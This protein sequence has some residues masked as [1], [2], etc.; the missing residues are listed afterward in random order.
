MAGALIKVDEFTVDSAVSS[1][2]LGGGSSGSSGLN[3]SI[4]STFDVYM[5]QLTNVRMATDARTLYIRFTAS[6]TPNTTSNYDRAMLNLRTDATF[7]E[8]HNTN[9]TFIGMGQ[10][11]TGTSEYQNA[12]LYLF[13]FNNSSEYSF[14]TIEDVGRNASANLTGKQGGG[15][16]TV[17]EANDGIYFYTSGGNINTGST[18]TLYGLKK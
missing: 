18:F 2:T 7:T 14:I 13:N 16:L 10:G 1:V 5:V 3:T 11:G 9:Q 12:T 4:D 17:T 6:G 8:V 15:V